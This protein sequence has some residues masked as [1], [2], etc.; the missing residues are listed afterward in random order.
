MNY[1]DFGQ[2]NYEQK[3]AILTTEG[4]LLMI[5]G[6]GTGKTFTLV[7]RIAYLVIEEGIRPDEI[8]VVTFTEKAAKELL[9]RISNEFIKYD[10]EININ[11]MYIGT[12]HS[13]CM[14][15]LKENSEYF[16]NNSNY[17]VLDA[18][19]QAYLVCRNIKD[20]NVLGY[21]RE[22]IRP[23]NVWK[24]SLEICRYVN[25]MMEEMVDIDAM[26]EDDDRDIR[27]LAKLVRRY[28]A[29]LE[30]NNALDFSSMQTKTFDM[31]TK[32]E[33]VLNKVRNK[34]HYI[35][36]DEYQDTNFIQEQLV[37]LIAG[38]RNNICVVGD[39][40]QGMYRFRGA[41]IRNILEFP[42]KFQDGECKV[43]H[44]DVNYRSE[45]GII[46]FY[47]R[48]MKNVDGL[49]LFNW[50]KYRYDKE[51][52]AG[53]EPLYTAP[54]VYHCG[55]DS[56]DFEKE[57]LLQMVRKLRWNHNISDYNQIAFLF[58]SVKSEEARKIA[59]YFEENGI[60]VY[61][62]RSDMFFER[63]EVKQIIGCIMMCFR[64]YISDL[65]QNTFRYWISGWLR[66]YYINCLKEAIELKK[67]NAGLGSYID[68]TEKFINDLSSE[69][70]LTLL[71]IFY[72][73]IAFAPFREYLS[74]DL[75]GNV[76][77]SRAARNLSEISRM[78][79]KY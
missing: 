64:I 19:E 58:R 30:R 79:S 62:P 71:D 70:E 55:G 37:F 17:R 76:I 61:S 47:N 15:I 21:Y 57:Y 63:T 29:L 2:A 59:E 67:A 56:I 65:K 50:D 66:G 49:N 5:A 53:K 33:D 26:E 60:P 32:H 20:F 27:F 11:D 13:V 12:F 38:E 46:D 51:I 42:F 77:E 73:I 44:L 75:T 43:I 48:W 28:K 22:Y 69:S 23:K 39:D 3:E 18:F 72:R 40:D 10:L 8:M 54:S 74:A 25:Q 41:T 36:V 14:R 31:L 6:P 7:K 52:H 78:I 45:P 9:T 1:Y 35:M 24:Q 68:D 16:E 4:P 34:I